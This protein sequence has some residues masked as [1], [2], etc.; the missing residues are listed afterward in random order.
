[1]IAEMWLGSTEG[2]GVAPPAHELGKIELLLQ[3]T[4]DRVSSGTVVHDVYHGLFYCALQVE[5]PL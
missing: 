2:R 1:M 3:K 4:V 5:V